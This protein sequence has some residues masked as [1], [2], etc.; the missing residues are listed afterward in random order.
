VRIVVRCQDARAARAAQERLAAAGVEAIAVAGAA[1]AMRPAPEGEDI[2]IIDAQEEGIEGAAKFA[3]AL[4]TQSSPLAVLAALRSDNPP[5]SGLKGV[6]PFSGAIAIDAPPALL[7][8]QIRAASRA[9]VIAEERRRRRATAEELGIAAPDLPEDR[10]LKALYIGAP[11]PLFLSLERALAAHDGL[12]TAAFTSFSGFD[13][14]HDECFDAVVLNG[15]Q[16]PTTAISL[17]A[18]LRR[19]A[20][21][22]YL[23]TMMMI[24]PDDTTTAAAAI[25]RGASA[26]A[27][28]NAPNGAPLGWLFEAIRRERSRRAAEADIRALRDLMGD[29]RTG[30]FRRKPFETHLAR[31]AAEHHVTGRSLAMAAL[32]VLPAHGA[33]APTEQTWRRG[34]TEISSLASRLVRDSDCGAAF[35]TD[36]IALALPATSMKGG[37]RTC[38]RVASVAECTAFASGENGAGPLV[39]EQHVVEMQPGESGEALLARALRVFTQESATA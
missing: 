24:A 36:L 5:P 10:Y 27:S 7:K 15:A 6:A 28:V 33:R 21:L 17:C 16:D 34:F 29:P 19:N 23:P 18:A 26:I 30:L 14:L 2:L 3:E 4:T 35:G 38:E 13:H 25:E 22:H 1:A 39:F 9:G 32:R 37:R 11:S 31:M 12:V 8:A 20:S